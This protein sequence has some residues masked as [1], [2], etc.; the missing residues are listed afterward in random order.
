MFV[1]ILAISKPFMAWSTSA[2]Y[3]CWYF[4]QCSNKIPLVGSSGSFSLILYD[5]YL[6]PHYRSSFHEKQNTRFATKNAIPILRDL[7]CMNV[8]SASIS[9]AVV[10]NWTKPK[11]KLPEATNLHNQTKTDIQFVTKPNKPI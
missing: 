8:T 2:Q 6:T 1:E 9:R 10:K 7:G 4:S 3:D 5:N 11:S